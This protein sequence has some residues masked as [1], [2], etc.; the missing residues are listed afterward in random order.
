M[1]GGSTVLD[2]KHVRQNSNYSIYVSLRY[3]TRRRGSCE[4]F[5]CDL[6]LACTETMAMLFRVTSQC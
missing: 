5:F 6:K 1:G 3:C 4:T 2:S